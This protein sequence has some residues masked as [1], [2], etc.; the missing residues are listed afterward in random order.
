ME[1]EKSVINMLNAIESLGLV[2]FV[3]NFNDE[4]GFMWTNDKRIYD[5][6]DK[7]IN[8]Y[9]SGASFACC[10]RECQYLLQNSNELENFKKKYAKEIEPTYMFYE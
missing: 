2:D 3:K 1:S 6:G 10:L 5:I 4:R 7:V 9:H 8:D